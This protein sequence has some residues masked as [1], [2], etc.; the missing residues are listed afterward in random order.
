MCSPMIDM[1]VIPEQER[2]KKLIIDEKLKLLK[3]LTNDTINLGSSQW[4]NKS[5]LTWIDNKKCEIMDL[6]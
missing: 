3:E 5:I 4:T 6:K 2:I 1:E